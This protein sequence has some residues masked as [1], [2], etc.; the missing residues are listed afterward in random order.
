MSTS[1]QTVLK[2]RKWRK[3]LPVSNGSF[4]SPTE[5]PIWRPNVFKPFWTRT[6]VGTSVTRCYEFKNRPIFAKG[7]NNLHWCLYYVHK[8]VSEVNKLDK[9]TKFR[10]KSKA[11]LPAKSSPNGDQS[12]HAGALN[13]NSMQM[14]RN[15]LA[16]ERFFPSNIKK[17]E[18]GWMIG[19]ECSACVCACECVIRKEREWVCSH[20]C[21]WVCV[22]SGKRVCVSVAKTEC[23]WW[24][25][26]IK[27]V[28]ETKARNI[29]EKRERERERGRGRE[30]ER[31]T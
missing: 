20:E 19:S 4:S 10:P 30:R 12:G 23:V 28:C 21:W 27:R 9:S 31:D 13:W 1:V 17:C 26:N 24:A 29:L 7:P 14:G 8:V 11:P 3:K 5:D 25:G 22:W 16:A 15:N 2:S 6:S 18:R